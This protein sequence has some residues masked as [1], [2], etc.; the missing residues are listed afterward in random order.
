MNLAP[1]KTKRTEIGTRL[2][3]IYLAADRLA[4]ARSLVNQLEIDASATPRLR[5]LLGILSHKEQRTDVDPWEL[6]W[7]TRADYVY[8]HVCKVI[9]KHIGSSARSLVD[10]GSN[11]TPIL[12]WLPH[13]ALRYS[14]DPSTPYVA[15][16]VISITDDFMQWTPGHPIDVGTCFQVLE[17]VPDVK[18]FARQLLDICEV[19]L[20]S[21]PFKEP[22]DRTHTHVH[23]SI[24][25]E[26]LTSWFGQ[27]PNFHYVARELSGEERI[28]A[29]FDRL[30]QQTYDAFNPESRAALSYRFRWSLRGAGIE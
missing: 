7:R 26:S 25:L 24:D 27:Q 11:R 20:V 29:L 16:G 10:V 8:L 2:I 23:D 19:V 13:V 17:H 9:L 18:R 30:S 6:Y 21:V 1:D 3:A 15:P 12:D 14:V 22:P 5:E 4:E 28:I